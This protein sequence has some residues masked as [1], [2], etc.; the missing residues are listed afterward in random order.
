MSRP[1]FPSLLHARR[2]AGVRRRVRVALAVSA[3]LVLSLVGCGGG[4][5]GKVAAVG[6]DGPGPTNTASAVML[7][8]EWPLTGE[9]LDGDLPDHPVYVVKMDNTSSSAPQVGLDSA[10][11]IVE[12]LVEGGLTRLAVFYY[13]DMPKTVGPVRS[14]RA[15]DIGIVKPV[16]ATIIASGAAGRTTARLA[17]A[18]IATTTEAQGGGFLRDGGRNAPYNLFIQLSKL[19][20]RPE[21]RWGAPQN[22]YLTFGDA[23]GFKGDVAVKRIAATFSGGHTTRWEHGENGWTRPDSYA[24]AGKDFQPDNLLLLRVR[25]RDAGYRDPAGNPV[26]ETVFSGKG[27]GVLVYGANAMKIVWAKPFRGSP[28]RLKRKNGGEVQVPVGRTWIELVP[29]DGGSVTL[30]K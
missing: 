12:E 9:K 22:P 29:A 24:E 17:G 7:N 2:L 14:M 13:R 5:A 8:G 15:S 21:K 26:P 6:A 20:D 3:V 11:L 18:K 1:C 4:D 16:S 19:A 30:T 10:D 27:E 28:L 25:T 23:S